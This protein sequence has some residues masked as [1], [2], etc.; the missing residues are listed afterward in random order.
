MQG[1]SPIP[2]PNFHIWQ[3]V[4][5]NE[6]IVIGYML[7]GTVVYGNVIYHLPPDS[8]NHP[9]KA[10]EIGPN[11]YK[12]LSAFQEK[13]SDRFF[14]RDEQIKELWKKFRNLHED[15]TKTRLLTVY[16]P[17]GSGKSSLARAGLIPELARRLLPGRE[18]SRVAVLVPS[19]D[20]LGSLATVLARV[21]TNDS[22]PIEKAEEFER[23]LRKTSENGQYDGLRR[24]ANGLPEIETSPLIVLVDQLEEVFTLCEDPAERD[25]FIG[26]LLYAAADRSKRVT[27]IVTLR[28]DLLGVTQNYPQLNQL[29]AS[30]GFLVPA[31]DKDSLSEAIAKPAEKARHPLDLSI[32]NLLIQETAGRE[33]ALPLLQFALTKIWVGLAAGTAPAETHRSIGGVGGALA[34]EAQRIYDDFPEEQGIARRIFLGLVQLGEGS[35]DTRRRVKLEQLVSHRDSLEQVKKTIYRFACRDFRLITLANDGDAET[36]EVTHEAL[37]ENWEDFKKWIDN[38]RNNL[39]FQRRLDEAARIWQEHERPEGNL[40]RSPNLDL[41]RDFQRRAG[42]DM[43]PLQ[44]E[45]FQASINAEDAQKQEKER[46]LQADKDLAEEKLRT[47]EI[48]KDLAEE[49][50]RAEKRKKQIRL[51][52]L[53]GFAFALGM[54]IFIIIN[55]YLSQQNA[56][57]NKKSIALSNQYEYCPKKRGRPGERIEETEVCF[58]NIK[59]SGDV[60]IF[61]SSANF[62]LN[63]GVEA[64]KEKEYEKAIRLFEQAIDGDRSDPIPRIFFNNARARLRNKQ[65]LKLAVVV[66]IDYYETAAKDVLRG[67]ADA[68]DEFNENPANTGSLLEVVIANDENEE[69]AAKEVAKKLVGDVDI[70][71]II[72]HHASE[73][74]IAAQEIY[75]L[76]NIAVISP[77][78]SSSKLKGENFFRTV[79]GTNKAAKLYTNIIREKLGLDS[80][81]IFYV[82]ESGYSKVLKDDFKASFDKKGR[83]TKEINMGKE[84]DIKKEIDA[85]FKN[86]DKA[87]L[88]ISHVKTNSV[89][90]A[91]SKENFKRPENQRMKLI[92]AMSL[93]EQETIEK[94]GDAVEGMIL[95]RP[96]QSPKYKYA[97]KI[98]DKWQLKEVNWRHSSSYDATQ[99]FLKAIKQSTPVNRQ[100]ILSKLSESKSGSLFFQLDKNETAGFGLKWDEKD[101]SN[102]NRKFCVV[103]VKNGKFVEI[104]SMISHYSNKQY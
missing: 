100:G 72:G 32:V 90:I 96:C 39:R 85:A 30:Q 42:D 13:D 102:D 41:L 29:I 37:F 81:T 21:A 9:L 67:V 76:Y 50:L 88:I 55:M 23:V 43:T 26:D 104:E 49:R 38:S 2:N 7:G 80:I 51:R 64:F 74:T 93:S 77:T 59:T 54:V 94:G 24:I 36:A 34:G 22:T 33:G 3:D 69:K 35:K 61:L 98:I 16:G 15:E 83:I 87:L 14:G 66:S 91:I 10:A 1:S 103:Q 99:A 97:K 53:I 18:R 4:K 20:P 70:L 62:H 101:R 60:G 75:K 71:G 28:S 47:A 5:S 78:S 92:S 12:G 68:Q 52:E 56:D 57:L 11:P 25:A 48:D 46:R 8:P 17:S 27:V 58:R 82:E 44:L 6:N 45:F 73:S 31:M 84:I 95:V 40:W 89:A 65:P 63:R 79:G 86:G 19:S